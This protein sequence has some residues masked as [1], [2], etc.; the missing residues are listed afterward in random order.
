VSWLKYQDHII[1]DL[2]ILGHMSGHSIHLGHIQILR[3]FLGDLEQEIFKT[4]P[5]LQG[6]ASPTR[7]EY[8]INFLIWYKVQG[9]EK[10]KVKTI[11]SLIINHAKKTIGLCKFWWEYGVL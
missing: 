1:G 9:G 7:W 4:D 6:E 8:S 11:K 10:M 2:N 5:I 3:K